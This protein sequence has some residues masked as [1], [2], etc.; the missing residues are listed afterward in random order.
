[1]SLPNIAKCLVI[2]RS[3]SFT[4]VI[5]G[6]SASTEEVHKDANIK[7]TLQCKYPKLIS[8][9]DFS[10]SFKTFGSLNS[11]DLD[12]ILNNAAISLELNRSKPFVEL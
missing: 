4:S 11:I 12:G 1:M 8:K 5:R 9:L 3:Q 2:D 7:F 10:N 6:S